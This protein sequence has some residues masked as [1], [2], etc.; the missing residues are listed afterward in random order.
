MKDLALKLTLT[1]LS[2][3]LIASSL[4]HYGSAAL[5]CRQSF[6]LV[7]SVI[8][9]RGA[10]ETKTR[11]SRIAHTCHKLQRIR[12]AP[13]RFSHKVKLAEAIFAGAVFGSEIQECSVVE[14]NKL[15]SAVV[16]LLWGGN[17]WCRSF[18]I[19]FT[20]IV[21]G[22]RLYCARQAFTILSMLQEGCSYVV[23]ICKI[24]LR[25]VGMSL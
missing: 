6:R 12:S 18:A 11:S 16:A 20:H 2:S 9:T 15:R 24:F 21:P 22:F 19:T 4:N 1:R 23:Q 3:L 10:P 17:T 5:K 7:G 8:T 25:K 14:H 13:V